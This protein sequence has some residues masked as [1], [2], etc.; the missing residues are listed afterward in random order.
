MM[1]YTPEERDGMVK[2]GMETGMNQ[3]Y[4]ALD[5]MLARMS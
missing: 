5:A 3:S 2:S 1:F 4:A